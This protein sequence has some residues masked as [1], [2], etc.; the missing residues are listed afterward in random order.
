MTHST[1]TEG[2]DGG[3]TGERRAAYLFRVFDADHPTAP[4]ARLN[5]ERFDELKFGRAEVARITVEGRVATVGVADRW[6]S[7]QHAR[8]SRVLKT[9]VLEDTKSKNGVRVRGAPVTRVELRDGDVIELGR[10]FFV[11]RASQPWADDLELG[12]P[13]PLVTLSPTLASSFD[14][15]TRVATAGITIAL[16]GPTGSGKEVLARA[17]HALSGRSGP[18]VAVNCGAL[19]DD[20]VESELFGHRRGAFSGATD[21]RTGLVRAAHGGTLLLDEVGDLPID[22]QP[23]LLRVLQEKQVTAVGATSPVPVDLRVISATH[24]SLAQLVG[25]GEF[26]DDLRARLGGYELALPALEDRREDLGLLIAALVKRLA[27]QRAAT[28]RVDLAAARALFSWDWPRNVREL[29]KALERALAVSTGSS[30]EL[31][32]LPSE[33]HR[34]PPARQAPDVDALDDARRAELEALLREH[35]GN[36][37]AV[38]RAM[39]KAR[40]Q[41]QR[42][43]RRYQLDPRD[44]AG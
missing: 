41:I 44:F 37:S 12:T 33:L 35:R 6:M 21:E 10:T 20:L 11:F 18:F 22:A 4:S 26:R 30:L 23:A 32:H 28:L 38:A 5:L 9:W 8:L 2:F 31:E 42:W 7:S 34:P 39:G 24:R 27:P 17:I 15:L 29:E 36:V 3:T 14:E 25:H 43:L 19:P 16:T 1:L 13:G 40:M